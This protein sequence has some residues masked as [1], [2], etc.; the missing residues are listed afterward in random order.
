MSSVVYTKFELDNNSPLPSRAK[1]GKAIKPPVN[2]IFAQ[3]GEIMSDEYWKKLLIKASK[4]RFPSKFSYSNTILTFTKGSKSES[5]KI[6]VDDPFQA[7]NSF[8]WFLRTK[9]GFFGPNDRTNLT[10]LEEDEDPLTWGNAGK[11]S[12]EVLLGYFYEDVQK[13][14]N[15]SQ[16]EVNQLK[17]VVRLGIVNRYFGSNNILV[18]KNRISNINGLIWN[19]DSRRFSQ[20]PNLVAIENRPSRKVSVISEIHKDTYPRFSRTYSERIKYLE[21]K[22]DR[23]RRN[24]DLIED[25]SSGADYDSF[26]N[27]SH[28]ENNEITD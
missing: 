6:P 28:N 7:A 19:A 24:R 17:N 12:R 26:T 14:L 13:H 1:K 23:S 2:P 4:G 9:G 22:R 18:H 11:K 3:A 27:F 10:L 20:D 15:L 25:R 5:I 21:K 8:C 16:V